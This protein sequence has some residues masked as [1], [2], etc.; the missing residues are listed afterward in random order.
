MIHV[1]HRTCTSENPQERETWYAQS[2]TIVF[3]SPKTSSRFMLSSWA[4]LCVRNAHVLRMLLRV[5]RAPR[6]VHGERQNARCVLRRA[7]LLVPEA[8]K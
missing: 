1:S 6:D 4:P 8:E 2:L 3:S 7:R 5:V